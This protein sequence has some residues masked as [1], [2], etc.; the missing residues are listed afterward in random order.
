MGWTKI[1]QMYEN[2]HPNLALVLL[3]ERTQV[4]CG[5]VYLSMYNKYGPILSIEQETIVGNVNLASNHDYNH[6]TIIEYNQ[7]AVWS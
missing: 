1:Q 5:K 4:E 6:A 7:G 3:F 2:V